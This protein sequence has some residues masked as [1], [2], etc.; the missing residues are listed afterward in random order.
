[1]SEN[2]AFKSDI[3]AEFEIGADKVHL[4]GWLDNLSINS[5][6]IRQLV[7]EIGFSDIY[8]IAPNMK[9]NRNSLEFLWFKLDGTI[10]SINYPENIKDF[11]EIWSLLKLF[12]VDYTNSIVKEYITNV[13]KIVP[14]PPEYVDFL[15]EVR[16]TLK[17][18][19]NH[20]RMEMALKSLKQI[21]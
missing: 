14:K 18:L 15:K 6:L 11:I 7:E 5:G 10:S 12:D 9:I 19:I 20:T 2:K 21:T 8:V 1:M 16:D 17:R 13:V 3:F 4:S